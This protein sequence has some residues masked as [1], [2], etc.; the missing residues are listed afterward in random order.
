MARELSPLPLV[1]VNT[2][3]LAM[4]QLGLAWVFA[5]L[6]ELWFVV[7]YDARRRLA[8]DRLGLRKWKKLLPDGGNWLGGGFAKAR[9]KS[10]DRDYLIRFATETRRGEVCHWVA[11]TLCSGFF[12][13]NPW[14]GDL[15]IAAY[16]VIANLP[17][18]LVQRYNRARLMRTS[19]TLKARD[20]TARGDRALLK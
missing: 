11:M 3:G 1:A 19:E 2:G 7:K 6:P 14:W 17:C 12:L 10:R 5:R 9:L 15:V 16:A 4:L 18:I 20:K 8:H 13:W